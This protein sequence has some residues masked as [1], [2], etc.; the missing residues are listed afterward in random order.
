MRNFIFYSITALIFCSCS[1]TKQLSPIEIKAMTAKQF[2]ANLDVTFK[3]IISL[4]QSEGFLV[5]SANKDVG[6]INASKRIDNKN[7]ELQR[8]LIGTSKD[9][10]TAKAIF[11][12]EEINNERT[13]VKLTIYEGSISSSVSY[14]STKNTDVKESMVQNATVYN[15]WFNNLRTEIE[16]RKATY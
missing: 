11:H 13:E 8:F 3:S 5:E 6:L 9:A 10:S 16:R 15:D 2:E 14:L 4:L 12:V 1:T 7:A